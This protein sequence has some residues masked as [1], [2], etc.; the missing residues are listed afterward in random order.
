[1]QTNDI[2]LWVSLAV[3]MFALAAWGQRRSA[4]AR[5]RAERARQ[6]AEKEDLGGNSYFLPLAPVE[7]AVPIESQVELDSLLSGEIESVAE[8]ARRQLEAPTGVGDT[9]D[10]P[11]FSLP[12]PRPAAAPQPATRP[13]IGQAP[14]APRPSPPAKAPTATTLPVTPPAPATA[15]APARPL[16]SLDTE[17]FKVPV[18]DLVLTW[19][20][21][22]GYR[23]A[24]APSGL[25]PIELQ[26]RHSK[27][28][29]RTYA[30]VAEREFVTSG[31]AVELLTKARLAGL[32]RV[33]IAAEAGSDGAAADKMRRVGIRIFDGAAIRAELGKIDISIAAKIIA[34]ARGRNTTRR[35]AAPAA[36]RKSK[37][38]ANL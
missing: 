1:M 19:F 16:Q 9:H 17:A 31:R 3:L 13:A 2:V 23:A 27:E 4:A 36:Q 30:F 20:E 25:N 8:K 21:A 37:E 7:E 26:L 11:E 34:I 33:L 6:E 12:A 5:A 35:A 28:P 14:A 29:G 15:A 38:P 10:G 18:R 32:S 22:R 24:A